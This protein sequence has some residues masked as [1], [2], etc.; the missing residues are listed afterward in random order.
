VRCPGAAK[1][2][3]DIDYKVDRDGNI[4]AELED[5]ENDS[6]DMTRYAFERDMQTSFIRRWG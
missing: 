3:E 1:Q 5:K 4:R 2:F 6:I